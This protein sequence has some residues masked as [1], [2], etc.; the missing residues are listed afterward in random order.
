M[1][2]YAPLAERIGMQE[3]KTELEDLAFAELHA[4]GAQLDPDAAEVP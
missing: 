2:I 1:E 4:R 3:I